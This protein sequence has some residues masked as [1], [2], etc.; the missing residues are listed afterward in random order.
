MILVY[1]VVAFFIAW[2]WVDYYRLIDVY[3][4]ESVWFFILA[5][6]L[7]GCST[8]LV[9]GIHDW[10]LDDTGWDINGGFINDFLY[11]TFGIGMLEEFAKSTP[12]LLVL[13]FRKKLFTDP[14]DYVSFFC[15]AALG[16][17]AIENVMYF[18]RHGAEIIEGRAILSTVGHMFDTA[19]IGYGIVLFKYRSKQ[20]GIWVIPLFFFLASL[21]HGIYDFLLIHEAFGILGY[22]VMLVYF[23]ATLSFFMV[24]LNNCLNNSNYFTYKRV[25]NSR[26]V[27]ERLLMYYAI[28]LLTQVILVMFTEGKMRAIGTLLSGL[29]MN[30]FIIVVVCL[31]LSRF[32]L[33][34]GRWNPFV[35]ELPFSIVSKDSYDEGSGSFFIKIKGESYNDAHISSYYEEYFYL[36][37]MN[38]SKTKIKKNKLAFIDGKAFLQGDQS[39]YKTRLYKDNKDS[40]SARILLK[41]KRRKP[42]LYKEQYPIVAILKHDKAYDVKH[43]RKDKKKFTFVEWAYI[44]PY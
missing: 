29:L 36:L 18:D 28:V 22:L 4:R 25:I 6:A 2:I 5:F 41:P 14:I 27:S 1:I 21:S 34:K 24:I 26:R 11:C 15:T 8:Q 7:G 16:F 33:I 44:K 30:G 39:F 23:M 38:M 42:I 10:F 32:K 37:P 20:H 40:P 31:R 17:S 9:L 35:P 3:D 43:N 12:F 13:L 19:L